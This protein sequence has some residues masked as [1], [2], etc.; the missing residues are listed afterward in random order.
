M[1]NIYTIYH[2]NTHV[3]NT[4]NHVRQLAVLVR[5][6]SITYK[7]GVSSLIIFTWKSCDPNHIGS[8]HVT[9]IILE[10]AYKPHLVYI[11]RDFEKK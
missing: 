6:L 9:P 2:P 7:N 8:V 3:Y 1:S 5:P 11:E 4:N 10:V